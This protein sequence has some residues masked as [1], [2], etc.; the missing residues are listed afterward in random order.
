MMLHKAIFISVDYESNL[1]FWV[2][3]KLH[4][5]CSSNLIGGDRRIIL[6]SYI[7]LK[8]PFALTVFEVSV[9]LILCY[10]AAAEE[11]PLWGQWT[12]TVAL[13]LI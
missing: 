12:N 6:T 7:Y 3:A 4:I 5:I 10:S 8:H 9:F 11:H 2:D 1:L 13:K